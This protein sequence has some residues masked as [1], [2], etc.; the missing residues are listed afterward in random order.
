MADLGRPYRMFSQPGGLWAIMARAKARR[1]K[2]TKATKRSPTETSA[3]H[4]RKRSSSSESG[5][6]RRRRR[7][8][9]VETES[10]PK[11]EPLHKRQSPLASPFPHDRKHYGTLL[12]KREFC[13][14]MPTGVTG[15]GSIQGTFY[16]SVCLRHTRRTSLNTAHQPRKYVENGAL[17]RTAPRELRNY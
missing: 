1:P 9:V 13:C 10:A 11:W 14:C 4:S 15:I 2:T 5:A 7:Q 3:K 16:V 12:L 6:Q 17:R 8:V